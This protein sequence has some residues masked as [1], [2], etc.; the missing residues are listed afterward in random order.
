LVGWENNINQALIWDKVKIRNIMRAC[1]ILHNMIVGDE[2]DGYTQFDV[3]EFVQP[4][5]TRSS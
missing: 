5:S 1:I 3:S 4:E 2:R